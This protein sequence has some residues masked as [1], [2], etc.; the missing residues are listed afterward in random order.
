MN[1][2]GKKYIHNFPRTE[3]QTETPA[4]KLLCC[5]VVSA[6]TS[7]PTNPHV[8]LDPLGPSC[9]SFHS[10][11]DVMAFSCLQ[12]NEMSKSHRSGSERVSL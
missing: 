6:W 9:S 7:P 12:S 4:L 11:T 2:N 8:N 10:D 1:L 5:G 3:T